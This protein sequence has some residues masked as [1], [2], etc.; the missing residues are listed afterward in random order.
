MGLGLAVVKH[1]VEVLGARL[2]VTSKPGEGSSFVVTLPLRPSAGNV[3]HPLVP[4]LIDTQS[5]RAAK[6]IPG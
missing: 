3:E 6:N 5:N 1:S 4:T 2:T